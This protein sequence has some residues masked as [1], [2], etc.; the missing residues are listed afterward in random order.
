MRNTVNYPVLPRISGKTGTTSA[1]PACASVGVRLI[2]ALSMRVVVSKTVVRGIYIFC[3]KKICM[4]MPLGRGIMCE[5]AHRFSRHAAAGFPACSGKDNFRVL[6][7]VSVGRLVVDLG[8][9]LP[10][11]RVYF[12]LLELF[13]P[14]L[15]LLL[16]I[17]K[18]RNTND[19]GKSPELY[20]NKL[21][22]R[23]GISR[24]RCSQSVR[25]VLQVERR[26]LPSA[27]ICCTQRRQRE[28][29]R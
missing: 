22:Q 16:C 8:A 12:L 5:C 10:A 1:A 11:S 14:L 29:Q 28:R 20:N 13:W 4:M 26:H 6:S 25:C 27:Y 7:L 2:L 15:C 21:L 24:P 3:A 17:H 19:L 18:D 23:V 9:A